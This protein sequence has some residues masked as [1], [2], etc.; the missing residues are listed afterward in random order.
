MMA[1]VKNITFTENTFL[2]CKGKY[3]L[4]IYPTYQTVYESYPP[5]VS[6]LTA[7]NLK[8]M[9]KNYSKGSTKKNIETP[10]YSFKW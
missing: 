6:K 2:N 5:T 10:E 8:G 4:K 1:G 9:K 7:D 3:L